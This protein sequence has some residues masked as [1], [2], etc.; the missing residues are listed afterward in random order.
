MKIVD[1]L[2]V[3]WEKILLAWFRSH[4]NMW[5]ELILLG[6]IKLLQKQH[7]KIFVI[8]H[9]TK[10]IESFI[11]QFIDTKDITFI[12]ELP[13]GFRSL[14]KYLSSP[15][16]KQIKY[17]FDIDSIVLWWWEILTEESPHSYYYWIR[18]IW[19]AL[20]FWKKLYIMWGIQ[21]PKKRIN[22][23]LCSWIFRYTQKIYTRD[24][25]ET[26]SL[27][28]F[29]YKNIEFFMDT[30]YFAIEN[31]KQFKRDDPH[32]YILVNINSKWLQFLWEIINQVIYYSSLWYDVFY[33]PVCQWSSDDDTKHFLSI[34]K[35]L[36]EEYRINFKIYDW[37]LDF[38]EF[39]KLLWWAKKII[40]CRLHLF[41]IS[42]FIWLDTMVFPYQKKIL[43][44][45]D[46]IKKYKDYL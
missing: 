29:G 12:E 30:S 20:F 22:K 14:I 7:K 18:S 26:S 21:A 28:A 6:N 46:M 44:M 11:Q 35:L 27:N 42:E 1:S 8:A 5:D 36:P 31:R 33:V 16:R 9:D 2:E 24:E 17:F 38:N 40:W 4:R 25:A 41:L 39:L 23:I 13:R 10:W 19:P 34:K 37:S 45:S 32:N 15:V 3:Q 43:K